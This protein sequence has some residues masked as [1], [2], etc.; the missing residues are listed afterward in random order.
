MGL[1]DE[2]R[3]TAD[4]CDEIEEVKYLSNEKKTP[5][6]KHVLGQA[7]AVKL[8]SSPVKLLVVNVEP[9]SKKPKL[10]PKNENKPMQTNG[11]NVLKPSYGC[12]DCNV[13]YDSNAKLWDH[14]RAKRELK[15]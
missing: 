3:S 14:L 12:A 4:L 15:V 7:P 5:P 9:E 13:F 11:T 1:L 6:V 10:E 2:M 8:R